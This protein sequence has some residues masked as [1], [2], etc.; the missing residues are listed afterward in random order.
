MKKRR[1]LS[2]LLAAMM[3]ITLITGVF[4]PKKEASAATITV[5][6]R[7]YEGNYDYSA[8]WQVLDLIN[9]QRSANGCSVLTMDKD[10]LEA[11]M[12]R[13]AE[14]SSS[15]SH[16]RPDGSSWTTITS[17]RSTKT[18]GENIAAGQ[19]SPQAAVTA[20]MSSA[21]HRSSILNNGFKSIGIG[22]FTSASGYRYYWVQEFSYSEG[23]PANRPGSNSNVVYGK[24]KVYEGTRYTNKPNVTYRVHVQTY[25]WQNFVF[26]GAIA[27]TS[28]QAKRLEGIEIKLT[29]QDYS[30]GISYR[31]HVQTYGW[32]T[33]RGNG[34]MAGTS[35]RAKRL[36]AIQ[37]KLTGEIA[38]H[39]DVYYRVHSQ[40]YGWM[41]WA[42]NGELSGTSGMA[43]RLEAIQIILLPKGSGKPSRNYEG[44]YS[45]TAS[46]YFAR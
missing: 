13:A 46:A 33:W 20:W 12:E 43:K 19:T 11:A 30:G 29:N 34:Q 4:V 23:T 6:G 42:R 2:L 1:K 45:S 39:Y 5:A 41:G 10:L 37:I 17:T 9:Q 40:T 15:F 7:T 35:G 36:E 44:V 31:T 26:N 25:A 18:Y 28:G 3:V 32:Q 21:P 27:G 22:C 14:I 24:G 8:A 38:N 16:S